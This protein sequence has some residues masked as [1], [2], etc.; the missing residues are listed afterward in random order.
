MLIEI[1]VKEYHEQFK[2]YFDEI[3][4]FCERNKQLA[5]Q[6]LSVQSSTSEV[7][8]DS[9]SSDSGQTDG[10]DDKQQEGS[11]NSTL[12]AQFYDSLPYFHR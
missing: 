2:L 10:Q 8:S 3:K 4:S 6:K 12:K 7:T 11:F 5:L 1:Q 9:E